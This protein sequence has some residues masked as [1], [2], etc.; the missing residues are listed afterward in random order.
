[1]SRPVIKV[2]NLS[3]RYRLGLKDIQAETLVGQ[4]VSLIKSPWQNLQRLREMSRFG[5]EDASVFWALK[6][7]NFEVNEGEV[8][9]IVGKNGAGKSTLLKILSQ[10]TEPTSGKIEMRGRVASLL[11]VGT[12]FHPELS[13]RE[14]IYMN[15]TILGMTRREID[16]KLE[17]IIEFSGVE[18]FID[19]AVKFYSSGM[20]VRLGF[21]VAAHLE[22]EILI[23]DEVLAVGDYE[24]QKKCLGKMED[25]ASQG[26]T[27]LFVSHDLNAIRGLCSRTLIV[28]NGVIS[29][30][31]QTAFAIDSYLNS[32]SQS[33]FVPEFNET[34][35]V[36][37]VKIYNSSD[38]I[39]SKIK[40]DSKWRIELIISIESKIDNFVSAIGIIGPNN[41]SVITN[42]Q[43]EIN[44]SNGEYL[45]CFEN[46]DLV[47]SEGEFK[48]SIGLSA[49][50]NVI[51]Y[52]DKVLS[53]N[54]YQS[55]GSGFSPYKK[56]KFGLL[57]NDFV[58]NIRKIDYN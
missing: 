30:I 40:C 44:V 50:Q 20:K 42:W 47:F 21:S 43:D 33:V 45:V 58:K 1:M 27:V 36:K 6:D 18:K 54:F 39:T 16:S 48:L 34:A 3:K 41:E 17:E 26:R 15:G 8:L 4:I 25:V 24:F 11:E 51:Q 32:N 31:G 13:G 49:N 22:P 19:T 10:I 14:N 35:W 5:V 28:N 52:L 37:E 29:F 38:E 53:I 7:I 46:K 57:S 9:G 56:I 55:N 12:G 23:I 2:E